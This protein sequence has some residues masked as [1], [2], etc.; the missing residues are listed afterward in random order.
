[1][2]KRSGQFEEEERFVRCDVCDEDIAIDFY[3]DTGDE[4]CCD[5]C[6]SVYV[7]KSLDPITLF[8]LGDEYDDNDDDYGDD[9]FDDEYSSRGYD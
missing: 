8:L 1:M 7:I 5:E 4:V 2:G 3:L 6:D 9:G